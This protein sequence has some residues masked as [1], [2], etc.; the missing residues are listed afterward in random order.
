MENGDTG[1]CERTGGEEDKSDDKR[2]KGEIRR[3]NYSQQEGGSYCL[4]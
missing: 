4:M 2:T 1:Q 3:Q